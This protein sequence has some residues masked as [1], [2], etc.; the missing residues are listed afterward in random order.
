MGTYASYPTT[1]VNEYNAIAAKAT[2]YAGFFDKNNDCDNLIYQWK[3]PS[4]YGGDTFTS[5]YTQRG[6]QAKINDW[7]Y[8]AQ[9]CGHYWRK[10][11]WNEI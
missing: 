8:N 5:Y 11:T 6:I 10:F 1:S 9:F 7:N 3:K 2:K 4:P